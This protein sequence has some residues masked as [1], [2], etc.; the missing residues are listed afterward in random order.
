[1]TDDFLPSEAKRQLLQKLRQIDLDAIALKD[2]LRRVP[3]Y[4]SDAICSSANVGVAARAFPGRLGETAPLS[5][6]K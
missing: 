5:W 3:V 2:R 1:M 6:S 4:A